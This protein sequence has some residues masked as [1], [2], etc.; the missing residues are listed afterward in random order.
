[1]CS[2]PYQIPIAFCYL[3]PLTP[4][5][6]NFSMQTA[7]LGKM[8]SFGSWSL[9]KYHLVNNYFDALIKD[10]LG[11]RI[12]KWKGIGENTSAIQ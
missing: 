7:L 12:R 6:T 1:M 8:G 5:G 4:A 11:M 2:V 9:S 3:V 10:T